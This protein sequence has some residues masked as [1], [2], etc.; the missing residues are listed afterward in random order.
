VQEKHPAM[1]QLPGGPAADS[2]GLQ[3]PCVPGFELVVVWTVHIDEGGKVVPELD[4]LTKIPEQ[5]LT[6]DQR[7][8]VARA[9]H[10][11]RTLLLLLGIE[12][13]ID[14]LIQL[15]ARKNEDHLS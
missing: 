7:E 6:L 2:M 3:S 15:C 11:F 10:C 4:L 5:A 8:V 1:V 13:A 14:S 12:A 9:P